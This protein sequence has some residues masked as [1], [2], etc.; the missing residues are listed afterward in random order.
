MHDSIW[1]WVLI[2]AI[3]ITAIVFKSLERMN[4][5][6]VLGRLAERGQTPPS[7][8]LR[9]LR[10]LP[11]RGHTLRGGIVTMFVG[12]GLA[13]MFWFMTGADG[14]VHGLLDQTLD[15]LPAVG[16]IPFA[17]G[18]GLIIASIFERKDPS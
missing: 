8:L 1:F 14:H 6:R 12:V 11:T 17:V 15:W 18:I 7:E 9:D 3:P 13:V 4:R 5:D 10:E 16:A 2:F